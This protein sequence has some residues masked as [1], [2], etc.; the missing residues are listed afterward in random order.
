MTTNVSKIENYGTWLRT[1]AAMKLGIWL[2]ISLAL[3]LIFFQKFWINLPSMLSPAFVFGQQ[4]ASPWGVL[5]LC[6]IFLCF[7][8]EEV[9]EKM[10][11]SLSL[12]FVPI[13]LG[14]IAG[15]VLMPFSPDYAVFQVLLASLGVFVILFGKAA[16][17]P[18]ILLAI[19]SFAISLP[20]AIQRFAEIPYARTAIVPVMSFMN[21]LSYP[22]QYEGQWVHFTSLTGEPMSVAITTA[23]AGPATMGV[24]MALF[25]LMTLDMPLP[26]KKA[27]WLFLFG[28]AG[29]WF[30]NLVRLVVVL[31]VGYYLGEQALWTAHLWTIYGLFPLWYLL[32]VYIYFRQS[33]RLKHAP[34]LPVTITDRQEESHESY[35]GT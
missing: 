29:T 19:Y 9:W 22:F 32:F 21:M 24:F 13:G 16:K 35:T 31:L 33:G 20:L 15:A 5:A 2:T 12:T 18:F 23:C 6:L 1:K 4:H 7:K 17:I 34:K 27:A 26:P 10:H 14:L 8:R 3:S 30:Q 11:E 25:A 28:V